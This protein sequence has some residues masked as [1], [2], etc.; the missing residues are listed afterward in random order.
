VIAYTSKEAAAAASVKVDM[1]K[2][3]IRVRALPARD[4]E[5]DPIVL[6]ADLV[7]WV[8]TLPTWDR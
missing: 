2:D 3:A 8:E 5:G 4:A 7:A 1:I 6:H